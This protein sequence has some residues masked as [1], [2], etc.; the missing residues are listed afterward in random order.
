LALFIGSLALIVIPST[1]AMARRLLVKHPGYSVG[2]IAD[3]PPE[4]YRSSLCTVVYIGRS[5]CAACRQAT[6]FLVELRRVVSRSDGG[7]FLFVTTGKRLPAE[8]AHAASIGVNELDFLQVDDRSL[9]LDSVPVVLT[10]TRTGRITSI[11]RPIGPSRSQEEAWLAAVQD[12][13]RKAH[14]PHP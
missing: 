8:R 7:R 11:L 6:P 13:I 12:S 2:E 14:E 10:V 5:T 9:R 1:R 4:C 3:L